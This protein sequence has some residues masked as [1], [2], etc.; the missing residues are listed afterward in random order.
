[1]GYS[2]CHLHCDSQT[3]SKTFLF[4]FWIS[5]FITRFVKDKVTARAAKWTI[6]IRLDKLDNKT[7]GNT[8]PIFKVLQFLFSFLGVRQYSFKRPTARTS[9][10]YIRGQQN[11]V[12]RG[13]VVP[14]S[15]KAKDLYGLT[16]IYV[17]LN[18]NWKPTYPSFFQTFLMLPQN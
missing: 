17:I 6:Q 11:D 18:K 3:M 15:V 16:I 9:L 1:M 13:Q 10:L 7:H 12:N 4:L 14:V 2:G 5:G 8:K